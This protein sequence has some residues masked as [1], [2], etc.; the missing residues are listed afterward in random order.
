MFQ[1]GRLVMRAVGYLTR[2]LAGPGP[3]AKEIRR[4][5]N[6]RFRD[7]ANAAVHELK[8]ELMVMSYEHDQRGSRGMAHRER[9]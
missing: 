1:I 5:E 3:L 4:L 6:K 9:P 2:K 7:E 8:T